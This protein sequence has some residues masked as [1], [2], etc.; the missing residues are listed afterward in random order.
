MKKENTSIMGSC[1]FG[2]LNVAT[3]RYSELCN[4]ILASLRY[5]FD[6][7]Q[8]KDVGLLNQQVLLEL[9]RIKIDVELTSWT[10]EIDELKVEI[11]KLEQLRYDLEQ[12]MKGILVI[13]KKLINPKSK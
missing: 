7:G 1:P 12:C 2:E 10:N 5:V 3:D 9:L 6:R 4:S 13:P 8:S 11:G